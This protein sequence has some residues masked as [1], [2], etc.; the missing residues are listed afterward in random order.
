M[1]TLKKNLVRT[2]MLLLLIAAWGIALSQNSFVTIN[3][4]LKDN[5]TGEKIRYATIAV[6][7]T[8]IGTV[9]NS[10]GE[11]T[12]KV[13]SSLNA[14]Y[15]EVS[16]MSYATVKF[17]ISEAA[18]KDKTYFLDMKP[19]QLK[20]I[21]VVPGDAREI[22]EMALRNIDKNYSAVPNMMT[23]FYR[24]S[25]RQR[26]D[27][28][29]I[30]EAVV[31]IY[32]APYLTNQDDQVKIFRG[33]KGS[34]VKKADTLMVQVQGGPNVS[35]LLDIVKNTDLSIALD[36]LDN[37][38]F[39]LG[40]VVNIDN[41]VNWVIN[42]SPAVINEEPLYFGKLCID[43]ET[44]AIT[45]AEFSLDLSDEGKASRVFI[46]KKPVGLHFKPTS[47]SYLVTYKQQNGKYYLNYVRVDL[48][49]SCD[50]KRRLFR[51]HYTVVSEVA[52]TD[53]R[54]G[55]IVKF[56]NSDVFKKSMVFTEK[57]QDFADPG[58]WGEYNIIEPEISI[59]NAIK[60][61]SKS[62]QK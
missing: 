16:H 47:T 20:E 17:R 55:N 21:S 60:K 25:I 59:E 37:Y 32:K 6:P 9:S 3:G 30:A 39:E 35:M 49:F 5:K 38:Q 19:I 34:N 33:R 23:G 7:N 11:F 45:R 40:N 12:L 27:Y 62:M 31:D 29:S 61:I 42:F 43:Q 14:E 36:N 48:K 26:R 18:G 10:E 56:A 51:N 1:K 46:Q 8:G 15:F 44:M 24:E 13:N 54:A 41:R 57:V 4:T 50:W 58:F 22:V 28:L 2:G 53:R 52:I